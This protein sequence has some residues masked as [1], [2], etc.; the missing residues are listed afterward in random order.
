MGARP[1]RSTGFDEELLAF[2]G[3]VH[4]VACRLTRG[5]AL[6]E[7]LTQETF[8]RA[9]AAS[10]RFEPGT[11]MRAWLLSILFN[12]HRNHQRATARHPEVELEEDAVLPVEE[13]PPLSFASVTPAVLDAAIAALPEKLRAVVMLRDLQGLSYQQLSEVL[14]IP[15]GTV[16]SRLHRGRAALRKELAAGVL[17]GVGPK[18]RGS[19][20][21]W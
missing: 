10:E 7:D 16:M 12:L 6:A 1:R 13:A 17:A 18:V 11:S 4:D 21:L 3:A 9:V 2:A 8:A 19:G 20:S 14:R 15:V 5:T